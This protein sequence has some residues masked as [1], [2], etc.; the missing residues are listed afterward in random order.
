MM[1]AVKVCGL[2]N[3][4]VCVPG[5]R[6]RCV[7]PKVLRSLLRGP[8]HRQQPRS[9]EL[10]GLAKELTSLE[11]NV[12]VCSAQPG[13][14][15]CLTLIVLATLLHLTLTHP[16]LTLTLTPPPSSLRVRCP[17]RRSEPLNHR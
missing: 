15:R 10:V 11:F 4:V 5:C 17:G 3:F 16:S 12:D 14:P 2:I 9:A 1:C 8:Q 7:T 13:H 6:R